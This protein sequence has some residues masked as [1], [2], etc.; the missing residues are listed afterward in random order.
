MCCP[1]QVGLL[2]YQVGW[3]IV[4]QVCVKIL[5]LNSIRKFHVL[6]LVHGQSKQIFNKYIDEVLHIVVLEGNHMDLELT[7]EKDVK[8][9][10]WIDF[11][12]DRNVKNFDFH[13]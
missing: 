13:S 2:Y 3:L 12:I 6:L 8:S 9:H 1:T 11:T 5:K 4:T 10:F 7:V